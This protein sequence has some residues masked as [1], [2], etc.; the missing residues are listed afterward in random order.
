VLS[1]AG[2][3]NVFAGVDAGI[4][5]TTGDSNSF[6]GRGA[7]SGNTSGA[8]NSFFGVGAGSGNITGFGNSFFGLQA[9]VLNTSGNFNSFFGHGAG[10]SNSIGEGNSFFGRS[11]GQR[12]TTGLNNSFFGLSAGFGNTSGFN[13]SFFG[14]AAGRDNTNSEGNSFFGQAAGLK[15]TSGSVNSF[16]GTQAGFN[17]TTGSVNSFFGQAAGL[18]NTTESFNTFIGAFSDG[19][20][21]I[22]NATAI[23][24]RAKVTQ[25]NSLVLGSISGVNL[26]TVSTNVGI[27]TTT[28][29][30]RLHV[31]NSSN[32]G[33]RVETQASGGAVA[34]F[35]SNGE[36]QIDAPFFAGGRFIVK[37]NGNIG[38]GI[39]P[40]SDRLHVFGIIRVEALGVAGA[41]T[42]CHNAS[43][44]I[45]TCSSSLRYKEHL[46]PFSTG[47]KLI[48]RLRPISFSW[49]A[50][51]QRDIGLVAEDVEKLEP[52][53]VTH[54]AAGEVEGVKYDRLSV[55]FINAFK[56]QQEQIDAQARL[57]REQQK[58]IDELKQL[59]LARPTATTQLKPKTTTASARRR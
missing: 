18:A 45:S 58:Q 53:L 57:I 46:S 22:T 32:L 40:P 39:N 35:A 13:N 9:G 5:N 48:S 50:S 28:P 26:A 34:S 27:G 10:F 23:G 54:N 21:G 51:D 43:F 8:E 16:F 55:A 12:N 25:S 31:I 11:A 19:Q 2:F 49:K 6:F 1:V 47:L 17:N 15:N 44:Q 38:L 42:L 33:L 36:F 56:E 52:L 7:G 37:E 24:Y 14:Q 30:F 4:N 20:A 41:T 3:S 59:V 29:S